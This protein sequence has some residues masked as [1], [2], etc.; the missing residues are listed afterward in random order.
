MINKIYVYVDTLSKNVVGSFSGENDV[1]T[2]RYL[3]TLCYEAL[4]RSHFNFGALKI[5][6]D[7]DVYVLDF[8][9]SGAM[10]AKEVFSM[11][12]LLNEAASY[13]KDNSKVIYVDDVESEEK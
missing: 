13:L 8:N 7:R 1:L 12:D 9:V 6:A 2:K 11:K 5:F 10:E 3:L 4:E